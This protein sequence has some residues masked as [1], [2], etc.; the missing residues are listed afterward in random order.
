MTREPFTTAIEDGLTLGPWRE[1]VNIASAAAGTIH[2][3]STAQAL[4]LRGGT[5]AGSIHMEQF[6]PLAAAQFGE[7]WFSRGGLSLYFQNA[8]LDREPVRCRAAAV[9][10]AGGLARAA[11]D[12]I[13]AKGVIVC[14]GTMS[15]GDEDPDST[16]RKR[17]AG[18]AKAP[19]DLR[20]LADVRVGDS[21]AGYPTRMPGERLDASLPHLTEP[22]PA[23]AQ[24]PRALP[25]NLAIDVMAAVARELIHPCG[26]FVGLYGGIEMRFI[27]GQIYENT[28]Y[29]LDG[30]VLALGETP[31]TEMVCYESLLRDRAG[32]SIAHMLMLTRLMKASSSLWRNA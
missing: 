10:R 16:M 20:M 29:F 12:M 9:A 32:A 1:P 18:L 21:V 22:M 2:E 28:E 6:V 13:D 14:A 19:V 5:I 15:C 4:G 11:V 3:D 27:N 24:A 17:L 23:Y 7:E 30:R 8:T 31:R 25:M 26:E